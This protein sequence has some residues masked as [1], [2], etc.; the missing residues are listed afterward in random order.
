VDNI[1]VI[2]LKIIKNTKPDNKVKNFIS[3]VAGG[4][5]QI[6]SKKEPQA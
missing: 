6:R 1:S 3:R 4:L 2:V 5:S